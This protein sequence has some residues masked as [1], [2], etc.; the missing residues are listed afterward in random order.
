MS[1]QL[2]VFLT[3]FLF[4]ISDTI[5]DSD[6][7]SII[8]RFADMLHNSFR[9]S[10]FN[11]R[12]NSDDTSSHGSVRLSRKTS[13]S[14]SGTSPTHS[15]LRRATS[16]TA[17]GSSIIRKDGSIILTKNGKIIS[18][19]PDR[20]ATV[21][22]DRSFQ[23]FAD[24][25]KRIEN[26]GISRSLTDINAFKHGEV[27]LSPLLARTGNPQNRS[28][29]S[30]SE[31]SSP[32]SAHSSSSKLFHSSLTKIDSVDETEVSNT[33]KDNQL[34]PPDIRSS[35]SS[36][37]K[38]KSLTEFPNET[39]WDNSSSSKVGTSQPNQSQHT[40][41]DNPSS[42]VVIKIESSDSV[43]D[44]VSRVKPLENK[45]KNSKSENMLQEL[46][47]EAKLVGDKK[48]KT[49]ISK[50]SDNVFTVPVLRYPSVER[51]DVQVVSRCSSD[52]S[53]ARKYAP[54][55]PLYKRRWLSNKSVQEDQAKTK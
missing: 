23:G 24:I 14:P 41:D 28:A 1:Y 42:P 55:S 34:K 15:L 16:K 37:A 32:S 2:P 27:E 3:S 18:V 8:R 48:S 53:I 43:P 17:K 38:S 49:N 10:R 25:D 5:R 40:L 50:S 36:S 35:R 9:S 21:H 39:N 20:N 12:R 51:L 26:G 4:V 11:S 33:Y 46:D 6:S 13:V 30:L 29:R 47:V 45:L 31:R 19:R 54:R 44:S 52:V 22:R 7:P